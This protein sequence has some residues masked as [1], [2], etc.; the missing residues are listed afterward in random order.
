MQIGMTGGARAG[1]RPDG[2]MTAKK[3]KTTRNA[4]GLS[5]PDMVPGDPQMPFWLSDRA[6]TIW[7][8]LTDVLRQRGQLAKDSYWALCA[9]VDSIERWE[10]LRAD[11]S[12]NGYTTKNVAAGAARMK[13]KL[14]EDEEMDET[15]MIER[16]RPTVRLLFEV[17]TLMR[18][19]L[20]EFGL[21]DVTFAKAPKKSSAPKP[22]NKNPLSDYGLAN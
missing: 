19:W 5:V 4:S 12:E 11:V 10:I 17:Q 16:V 3:D 14:K 9:L 15:D 7:G 22:G 1:L 13:G 18:Y 2:V 8:E 20:Q 6:I 21:T